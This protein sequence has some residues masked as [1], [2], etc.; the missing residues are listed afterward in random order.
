MLDVRPEH[1][2]AVYECLRAFEP[3]RS[4]H[5]PEAEEIE[6]H[7]RNRYDIFGEYKHNG[8]CH[9]V[10]ISCANIGSFARLVE[11]VGHEMLHLALGGGNVH[12]EDFRRL[13]RLACRK[14]VWDERAF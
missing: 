8:T 9:E 13:A 14:M 12:G 5:L 7:V 4:L 10:K 3:W 2:E 1:V 11:T 6:F